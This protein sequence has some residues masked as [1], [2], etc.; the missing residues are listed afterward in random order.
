M[1]WPPIHTLG[2]THLSLPQTPSS[3]HFKSDSS[4]YMSKTLSTTTLGVIFSTKT[5]TTMATFQRT[6]ISSKTSRHVV[7][8]DCRLQNFKSRNNS[9][10]QWV[11][12]HLSKFK[13]RYARRQTI[14]GGFK[15]LQIRRLQIRLQELIKDSLF[16]L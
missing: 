6:S 4:T 10:K 5:S 8:G 13:D 1:L 16:S 12:Y 11:D 9:W 14:F 2:L 3:Q 15:R 7:I